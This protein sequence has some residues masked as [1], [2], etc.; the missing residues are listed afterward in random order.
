MQWNQQPGRKAA[1]TT[2]K[3]L[4]TYRNTTIDFILIYSEH[5]KSENIFTTEQAEKQSQHY[6]KMDK[7]NYLVHTI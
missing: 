7:A 2:T 4:Y 1:V 3:V 5:Y 6:S